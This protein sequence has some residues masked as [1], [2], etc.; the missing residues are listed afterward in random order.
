MSRRSSTRRPLP[1][2][3]LAVAAL[4]PLLIPAP[5]ASA[6]A[7]AAVP[8]PRE[9]WNDARPAVPGHG[10]AAVRLAH[11][12][13]PP[14]ATALAAP[15]LRVRILSPRLEARPWPAPPPVDEGATSRFRVV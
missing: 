7:D 15:D 3:P 12:P 13:V 10:Q 14:A 8:A 11:V 1:R 5:H 9:G 6:S 2:A 4:F